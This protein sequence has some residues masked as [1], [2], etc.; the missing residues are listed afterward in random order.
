[1]I[2]GVSVLD[3]LA[4]YT[5]RA[6]E[7]V[8]FKEEDVKGPDLRDWLDESARQELQFERSNYAFWS[9]LPP[10]P[11]AQG[12]L[13]K[14]KDNQGAKLFAYERRCN[15]CL[16]FSE[17]IREWCHVHFP[18]LF[19]DV[20]TL[21]NHGILRADLKISHDR[22]MVDGTCL[23]FDRGWNRKDGPLVSWSAVG[24]VYYDPG[25]PRG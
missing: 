10:V 4:D 20:V 25:E 24:P 6:A 13:T 9:D 11:N 7:R 1:M 15:E 23:I 21:N 14:L 8:R 2:V 18:G 17:I 12:A 19:M 5:R 3:V 16:G 22:F